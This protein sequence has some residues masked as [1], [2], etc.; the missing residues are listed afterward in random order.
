[1]EVATRLISISQ[2]NR[3]PYKVASWVFQRY[4]SIRSIKSTTVKI[5]AIGR[6]AS[7]ISCIGGVHLD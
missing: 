1:M 6:V 7:V 2:N 3:N 4:P 5:D